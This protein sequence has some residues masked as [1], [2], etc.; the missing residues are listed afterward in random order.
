MKVDPSPSPRQAK[1]PQ[2][3]PVAR[4]TRLPVD[5]DVEVALRPVLR[6]HSDR[7]GSKS[8]ERWRGKRS[9]RGLGRGLGRSPRLSHLPQACRDSAGGRDRLPL[10]S[11][12][13]AP[14]ECAHTCSRALHLDGL[15]PETSQ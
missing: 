7:G 9:G 3:S 11:G 10:T 5:F 15:Q 12:L 6:P 1:A 2:G 13:P 4:L 8:W 14:M